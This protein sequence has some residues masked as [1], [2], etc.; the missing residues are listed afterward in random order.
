MAAVGPRTDPGAGA[1]ALALAAELQGETTC[2]ICLELF[3][4]PVSV[5]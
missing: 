5:E 3:R 4:E 2:S 1:E